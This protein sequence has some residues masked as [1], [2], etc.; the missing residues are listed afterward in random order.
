MNPGRL[1]CFVMIMLAMSSV[2]VTT[3]ADFHFGPDTC[4]QGYVWREA[5]SGD[6]V[7][8]TGETRT[9]AAYDNS[10]AEARRVAAAVMNVLSVNLRNAYDE[11]CQGE[12][13]EWRDRYARIARWMRES[14]TTPDIMALQEAPGWWWCPTNWNAQGDYA[15]LHYLVSTINA[16]T[17]LNYRIAYL[18][19]TANY[20]GL[21]NC[22]IG[23]G[24]SAG[25]CQGWGGLA[26]V[27][28]ADRLRNVTG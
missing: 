1:I 18:V 23:G 20:G 21:G 26:L 3:R 7:C 15:A 17:N 11:P 2:P 13:V 10:Q 5:F 4:R 16:E 9:Q 28:N 12:R 24:Q 27:Y 25:G 19:N 8:V 22:G 6:H 14:G